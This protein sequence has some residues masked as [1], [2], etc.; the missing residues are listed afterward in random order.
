L[1]Q[2]VEP[3]FNQQ[4]I[5]RK[6]IQLIGFSRGDPQSYRLIA[7]Q[8]RWN[9]SDIQPMTTQKTKGSQLFKQ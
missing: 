2:V 8:R 9:N 1:S 5:E 7:L 6:K 3:T 4:V